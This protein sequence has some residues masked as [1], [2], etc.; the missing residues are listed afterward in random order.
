MGRYFFCDWHFDDWVFGYRLA[1]LGNRLGSGLSGVAPGRPVVGFTHAPD[2]AGVYR[3]G[4]YANGCFDDRF[5]GAGF[6]R[7]SL[8]AGDFFTSLDRD[9][10]FRLDLN[11]GSFDQRCRCAQL[12]LDRLVT[13]QLFQMVVL[14]NGRLHDVCNRR[15]AVHDDP[16]TVFFTLNA[17]LAKT[18]ITHGITNAGG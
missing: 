13:P 14:A 5:F 16:F 17:R 12:E 6:F 1:H 4:W 18:G 2:I 7:C 15:S 3:G 9:F 11:F 8:L 10:R